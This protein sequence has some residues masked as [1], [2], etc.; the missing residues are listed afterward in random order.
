MFT[1]YLPLLPE[2]HRDV[3]STEAAAKQTLKQGEPET[4]EAPRYDGG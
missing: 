4:E 3:S 1:I 2:L